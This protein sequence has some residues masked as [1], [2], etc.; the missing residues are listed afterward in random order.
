MYHMYVPVAV[1]DAYAVLLGIMH[2]TIYL[3]KR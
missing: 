1:L 2:L 3:T